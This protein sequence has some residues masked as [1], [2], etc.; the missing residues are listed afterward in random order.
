[1]VTILSLPLVLLSMMACEVDQARLSRP[2]GTVAPS[3]DAPPPEAA[4]PSQ[5]PLYQ[6]L[7]AGEVGPHAHVRGQ[8]AR[9]LAWFGSMALTADQLRSLD[10]LANTMAIREARIAQVEAEVAKQE[11][12]ALSAI[13][14]SLIALLAA[15]GDLDADALEEKATDLA[16]A[17]ETVPSSLLTRTRHEELR[18]MLSDANSWMKDLDESQR[19]RLGTSRFLLRHRVGALTSPGDH[20]DLLGTVWDGA[21]FDSLVLARV[22]RDT[23]PLDIG[24]LWAAES[25]R[26]TP[27]HQLGTIQKQVLLLMATQETGLRSAIE[28][29]LGTRDPLDFSTGPTEAPPEPVTSVEG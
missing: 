22:P 20:G 19:T 18:G 16:V 5:Q 4:D 10:A 14:E 1:V 3:L 6:L 7:F 8:R 28:V 9:M 17:R 11:A 13:Y 24:G 26:N 2:A 29:A 21:S 25:V 27:D 15:P 23:E 12:E